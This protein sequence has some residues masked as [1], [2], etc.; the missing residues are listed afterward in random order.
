MTALDA[1]ADALAVARENAT[2]TG[3]EIELLEGDLY[4]GLPDGPWDLVVSNPPYVLPS[5]IDS[6][7]PEVR[8]W[9]PRAAL[10]GEGATEAIAEHARGVLRPGGALV[11]EVAAGDAERVA[12][13]SATSAT[14][15]SW[16]RGPGRAGPG[17]RG[18]DHFGRL[19]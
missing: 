11:L 9:E 2:R 16:P 3:L 4:S 8:D 12:R 19:T 10:V 15:T 13:S 1:S 17:R 18:R 5:E 14:R 6:L 7:E